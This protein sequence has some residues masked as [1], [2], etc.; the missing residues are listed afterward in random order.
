MPAE[1]TQVARPVVRVGDEDWELMAK[2]DVARQFNALPAGAKIRVVGWLEA[3]CWQTD[4]GQSHRKVEIH[5][6][7]VTQCEPAIICKM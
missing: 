6:E 4:G 2:G 1:K 3:H 7:S 5:V